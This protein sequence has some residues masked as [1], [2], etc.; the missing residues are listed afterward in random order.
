MVGCRRGAVPSLVSDSTD[1]LLV[2]WQDPGALADA[3]IALLSDPSAPEDGR[4]GRRKAHQ[5][6][7]WRRIGEQFH[8]VYQVVAGA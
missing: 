7:T 1:G 2:P 5:R 4:A 3:L 8:E 6:Y